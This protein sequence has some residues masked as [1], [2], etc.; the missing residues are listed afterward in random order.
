MALLSR[1]LLA[2]VTQVFIEVEVLLLL[3]PKTVFGRYVWP[4]LLYLSNITWPSVAF[5]VMILLQSNDSV[6]S[7]NS[8][9]IWIYTVGHI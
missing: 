9:V 8:R 5:K 6:I 3:W 7:S 1:T 2:C 4:D